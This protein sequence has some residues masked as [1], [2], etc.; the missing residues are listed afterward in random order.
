MCVLGIGMR[1]RIGINRPLGDAEEHQSCRAAPVPGIE[2][3]RPKAV[4]WMPYHHPQME[5]PP[6]HFLR[7]A[8]LE[9][10]KTFEKPSQGGGEQSEGISPRFDA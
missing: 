6:T 1:I 5:P 2:R 9:P 8:M 7:R 10:L 4:Q 3:L